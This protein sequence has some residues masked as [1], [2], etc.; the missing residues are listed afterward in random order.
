MERLHNYIC[1]GTGQQR[2]IFT[3]A[4]VLNFHFMSKEK[5]RPKLSGIN[6][7]AVHVYVPLKTIRDSFRVPLIIR[8]NLSTHIVLFH[9]Q[10]ALL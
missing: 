7:P 5:W 6:L 1:L 2:P 3:L 4:D 10:S 8:Y 9:L